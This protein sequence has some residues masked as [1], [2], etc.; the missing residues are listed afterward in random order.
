MKNK[1][2]LSRLL[3]YA[4]GLKPLAYI[5]WI[6]SALSSI[7]ALV[8]YW[9]LWK[10][11]KEVFEVAPNFQN[12]TN[13]THNGI[14]ALI[15]TVSSILIYIT[16]LMCSHISAFR[17]A[18]N[19][20]IAMMRHIIKLPIGSCE[21]FGS[22]RLRKIVDEAS[23]ETETY[24]AHQLPDRY[25]A[26]ATPIGLLFLLFSFD[27]RL[28]LLSILPVIL[29]FAIMARMTGS[30]MREKMTEYQNS[31]H[32]M[33]NQAV[34][35]VRG[36]PVVKTFGQTIFSFKKFK[37]SIDNYKTWVIDYTKLCRTPM[38]FYTTAINSVFA[39]LIAGTLIISKNGITSEFL[40]NL[41]FYV[42]ITPI[43]SLTLTK[44]MYQS[45][46]ALLVDDS[47]KR[48]DSILTLE[49][50][51]ES[52][53]SNIPNDNSIT[54]DNISFSYDG[55]T[56]V[57][58]NVSLNIK[59]GETIAFVGPSGGGKSTLASLISRFF[60][61]DKGAIRIGGIDIKDIQKETLMNTISFV[62]QNSKLIKASI[63]EN[64]RMGKPDATDEQIMTA[65][66][67]AQC[68]DI[69]EKLPNGVNTVIGAK[70][71]YL[72]G[73]EMQRISIARAMLK[74]SPIVIL[75]EATAFADPDNEYKVQKAFN[76]LAKNKTVIM[77]AHRLSTITG[78]DKIY[79]IKDGQIAE[80]GTSD[81][82]KSLG[83]IFSDMW[84]NYNQ[85]VKWKV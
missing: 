61:V 28:G 78:A 82:L 69:I 54:L 81:E 2:N 38:L 12:A 43:I 6:L 65:L 19:L 60:D 7:I 35:Y 30:E 33:S 5:A 85:S 20:R 17:I 31:L 3:G 67:N 23:G 80:S 77:I 79:V 18:T 27:W 36:I 62:F 76:E 58:K 57:I 39:F 14:M 29:A 26:I 51:Y 72:S 64:V 59:S 75:D 21:K 47:F 9:Y 1:S 10:I 53:L 49:P 44:I 24:L 15:F 84:K 74:N 63:L 37:D 32:D 8:P 16:A 34:E 11:F 40:L 73:G 4:E 13:L 66:K 52:D 56:D 22:G 25:A 46:N 68:M 42:I 41:I 45:E 71:V 50:L 83:G 55:E 70:G 48:I